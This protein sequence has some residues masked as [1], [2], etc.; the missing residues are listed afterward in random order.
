MK[1]MFILQKIKKEENITYFSNVQNRFLTPI[2]TSA[3]GGSWSGSISTIMPLMFGFQ[4]E[5]RN[6]AFESFPIF[7]FHFKC[8]PH[9]A[10]GRLKR[11]MAR[12]LERR[13]QTVQDWFLANHASSSHRF[14]RAY[15]IDLFIKTFFLHFSS[16]ANQ[17]WFP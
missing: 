7:A 12:I 11:H 8:S 15:K 16:T 1:K 4:G 3:L 5:G 17:V 14:Q 2:G 13:Q 10:A 9:M 6:S